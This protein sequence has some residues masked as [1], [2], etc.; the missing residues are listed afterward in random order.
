M[1]INSE[2]GPKGGDEVNFNFV[3]QQKILNYGWPIASY[4]IEY[5]GSDPYK[6]SHKEFGRDN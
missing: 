1:I 6:K 3:K 2:H 4:G 5:D